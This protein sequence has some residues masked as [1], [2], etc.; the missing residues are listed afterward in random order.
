MKR[1]MRKD[2]SKI[3][4]G[5]CVKTRSSRQSRVKLIIQNHDLQMEHLKL[6]IEFVETVKK[7]IQI[8]NSATKRPLYVYA[9]AVSIKTVKAELLRCC[10]YRGLGEESNLFASKF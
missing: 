2:W 10:P 1:A 3:S 8:G 7:K 4:V 9:H 6:F 5:L